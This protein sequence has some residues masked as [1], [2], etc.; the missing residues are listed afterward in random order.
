MG[1]L[2][3]FLGAANI[4]KPQKIAAPDKEPRCKTKLPE[5]GLIW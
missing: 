1:T 5:I 3:R 2:E 4:S